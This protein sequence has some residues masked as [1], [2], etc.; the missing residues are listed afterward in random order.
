MYCE[1]VPW[2]RSR[3]RAYVKKHTAAWNKGGKYAP[4]AVYEN[5][6]GAYIG[7]MGV[8]YPVDTYENVGRGHYNVA[9]IGYIIDRQYWGNGYGS[10]LTTVGK[11]YINFLVRRDA[12]NGLNVPTEATASS[13]PGNGASK[14]ILEKVLKNREEV[15]FKKHHG[16]PRMM[17][18][19]PIKIKP[20]NGAQD[21]EDLNQIDLSTPSRSTK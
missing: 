8:Y 9:E 1:G 18:F 21:V 16:N 7:N 19:K 20:F 12:A 11:K 10:E 4:F 5:Q 15:I 17:F 14:R 2:S 6:T 3:V 13:H